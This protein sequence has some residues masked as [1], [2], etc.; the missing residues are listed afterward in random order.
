MTD[1]E[2][3]ARL[4]FEVPSEDPACV[5]S[6]RALADAILAAGYRR[7]PVLGIEALN[8]IETP[9][10]VVRDANGRVAELSKDEGFGNVWKPTMPETWQDTK[11]GLE[12]CMF[13]YPVT[14]LYVPEEQS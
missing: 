5:P 13:K 4:I 8:E 10:V 6:P 12:G 9:G 11:F 2:E 7:L 1:R 14:V 3:L